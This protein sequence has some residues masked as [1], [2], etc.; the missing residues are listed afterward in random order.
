AEAFKA[1]AADSGVKVNSLLWTLGQHDVV[2]TVEANDDIAATA[3]S[4]SVASLGNVR[5]QTLK[6]FDA[7]D[8]AKIL[9]KMAV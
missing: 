6:A 1:M 7:A 3:L 9:G 4:L 2:A 5:T 8:M